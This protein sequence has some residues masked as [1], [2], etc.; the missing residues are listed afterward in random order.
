MEFY[1]TIKQGGVILANMVKCFSVEKPEKV[2][3]ELMVEI[4]EGWNIPV[5]N[6]F[7]WA[8]FETI[9]SYIPQ[10]KAKNWK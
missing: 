4:A 6:D 2:A 5:E 8:V 3:S 9:E 10:F 1:V 7:S